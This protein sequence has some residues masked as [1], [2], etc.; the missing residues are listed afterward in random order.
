MT[1]IGIMCDI[2][3]Y[4]DKNT[5]FEI[6]IRSMRPD[7]IITDEITKD[8]IPAIKRGIGSGVTTIAS[9][10]LSDYTNITAMGMNIFD[11]YIILD[12][13]LIGKIAKILDKNGELIYENVD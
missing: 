4:A 13:D 1:D 2:I 10:H 9:A 3:S 6:G 7:I 8:D 12:K 5:A 11:K